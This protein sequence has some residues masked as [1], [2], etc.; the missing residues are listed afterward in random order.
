MSHCFNI[1]IFI[2]PFTLNFVSSIAKE[3]NKREEPYDCREKKNP[4]NSFWNR[5]LTR[6]KTIVKRSKELD[7][8]RK[9]QLWKM[10][11]TM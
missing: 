10:S 8:K 4:A 9:E 1:L 7:Q 3:A 6:I 2:R 11:E 5:L